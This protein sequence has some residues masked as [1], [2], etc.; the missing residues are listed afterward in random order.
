ML[1]EPDTKV[2][3]GDFRGQTGP[4]VKLL[5]MKMLHPNLNLIGKILQSASAHPGLV[6]LEGAYGSPLHRGGSGPGDESPPSPIRPAAARDSCILRHRDARRGST[7]KSALASRLSWPALRPSGPWRAP[8]WRASALP[9]PVL[10]V[11]TFAARGPLVPAP[12]P[13]ADGL[14]LGAL[15]GQPSQDRPVRPRP[16]AAV[17]RQLP[18]GWASSTHAKAGESRPRRPIP[19]GGTRSNWTRPIAVANWPG[20]KPGAVPRTRGQL[21]RRSP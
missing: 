10:A 2:M 11:A 12:S 13:G 7:G 18:R 3:Q 17:G 1:I 14:V 20:A 16:E 21:S 15:P 8:R 5:E 9:R 4:E 6:R 19:A